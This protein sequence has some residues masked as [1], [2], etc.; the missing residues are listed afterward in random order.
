MTEQPT[1]LSE[2]KRGERRVEWGAAAL[3]LTILVQ[4]GGIIWWGA[5]LDQRV[6]TVEAR[7]VSSAS[8]GETIARLDERTAA[9]QTSIDRIYLQLEAGQGRARR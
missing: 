1:I 8:A 5:K 6:S 7:V 3:G 4:T 2:M 9:M